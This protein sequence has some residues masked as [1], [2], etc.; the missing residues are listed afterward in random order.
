MGRGH[1]LYTV[2]KR[3]N[4]FKRAKEVHEKA[5]LG[6][7]ERIDEC[8][9]QINTHNVSIVNVYGYVCIDWIWLEMGMVKR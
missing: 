7:K 1:A 5:K 9:K 6:L 4:A 2:V 8:Q 3:Y